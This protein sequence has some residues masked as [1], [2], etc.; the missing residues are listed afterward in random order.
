MIDIAE[1]KYVQ[2]S[3]K[4][5]QDEIELCCMIAIRFTNNDLIRA[6]AEFNSFMQNRKYQQA[7]E[8]KDFIS[9]WANDRFAC[10]V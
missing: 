8:I 2:D 3:N 9:E 6:A 1:I 7:K 5:N 10:C 4:F